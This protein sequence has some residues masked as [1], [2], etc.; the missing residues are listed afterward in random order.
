MNLVLVM[1]FHRAGK[2]KSL[3]LLKLKIILLELGMKI[4]INDITDKT[5]PNSNPIN[6]IKSIINVNTK[7]A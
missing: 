6:K 7:F 4:A 2:L 3:Q 5:L 1:F